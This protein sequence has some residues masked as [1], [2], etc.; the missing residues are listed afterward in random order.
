ML[1]LLLIALA[2]RSTPPI[3]ER[4]SFGVPHIKA[5][6]YR[7]AFFDAGYAVAQDRLWQMELSRRLARG[8]L[9][10]ILGPGA[11]GSDREILQTGYTD[12]ELQQQFDRLSKPARVA[13]ESYADGVNGWI[14]QAR[15]TGLPDAYAKAAVKP[16]PWTPLDTVAI[17]V[18]L[19]QIFGR[20][21]AG[22]LRNMAALAY[23]RG[24]KPISNHLL[25]V[26]DDLAWENDPDAIPTVSPRDDPL[27]GS[28]FHFYQPDRMTTEAHLAMLPKLGLLEMLAGIGV[29]SR[30]ESTRVAESLAT[31]FRTGSYC[32]VVSPSHSTS[33]HPLLL[34]GPQMGLRAPS[35]VHEMSIEAPG[36]AT[37]GM[38]VPGIPGVIVGAT[39]AFAWGITSGVA[40]TDDLFFYPSDGTTYLAG[41]R[42]LPLEKL[43][44]KL[45]VKDERDQHVEQLRTL[46]GPIILN[47]KNTKTVFARKA[48]YWK[49]EMDTYDAWVHLWTCRSAQS[50]E[51]A[52]ERTSM[53]FNFLYATSDGDIGWKYL[54]LVPK[55]ASGIDPRFP[56]PGDSKFG[57]RGFLTAS[58]MPYVRNPKSGFLANWNNKPVSWWP[59]FDTP[60]WGKVF[61]NSS[62]LAAIAKPR[63]SFEDLE[64]VPESIAKSDET[65][66]YFKPYLS[67]SPLKDFDGRF[68]DGSAQAASYRAFLDALR[69]TLFLDKTGNFLSPELFRTVLQPSLILRALEGK[70]KFDYRNGRTTS[71]VVL[72]A[73]A[74]V[75][76]HPI[77]P[78]KAGT[79]KTFDPNPIP[80][81]NR[82]TYIQILEVSPNYIR[83]VN[84]LPPGVNETGKHQ[85]D[86][87]ALARSWGYKPMESPTLHRP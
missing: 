9:A 51:H 21:G 12:A 42:R 76:A 84:V 14:A 82:G 68:I 19:L 55:R 22:E 1:S 65:W 10:E 11:V 3:I 75:A 47:S 28:H 48:G 73:L 43:N 52:M 18:H 54:G 31:P 34:S 13:I 53:N 80:Y 67:D 4:D 60:T 2:S 33:S 72:D 77:S 61:E 30:P 23:L 16:E 24:Q 45:K 58:E 32:V 56:T 35:V 85:N 29:A 27:S 57:W 6:S 20:G 87:S 40:D 44:F 39:K 15:A 83:G 86:Q 36:F 71:Q 81:S 41:T 79:F 37:V 46:D 78:F 7:E 63:L 62:L 25:D 74:I 38:D 5:A 70:T 49:R 64:A 59:N 50:I 8:Q 26:W 69:E 66:P 17:C